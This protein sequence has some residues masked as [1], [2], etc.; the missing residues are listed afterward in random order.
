VRDFL[1]FLGI[2]DVEFVYAEGLAMGDAKRDAALAEANAAIRAI[3]DRAREPV[4][5][6]A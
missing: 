4:T 2:D 6:A 3:A 5:L 1:R